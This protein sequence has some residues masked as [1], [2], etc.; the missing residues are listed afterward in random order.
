MLTFSKRV[1]KRVLVFNIHSLC[2]LDAESKC[3]AES[4]CYANGHSVS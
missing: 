3:F 2:E 4:Q 1:F